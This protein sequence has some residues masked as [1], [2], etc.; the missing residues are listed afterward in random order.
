MDRTRRQ[1]ASTAWGHGTRFIAVGVLVAMVGALLSALSGAPEA[2]ARPA[3]DVHADLVALRAEL[4]KVADEQRSGPASISAADLAVLDQDLRHTED[5]VRA[6]TRD[7]DVSLQG[8][9]ERVG[10]LV[11]RTQQQTRELAAQP[12]R[13]AELARWRQA[14][15]GVE[16]LERQGAA[17]RGK[18]LA[19]DPAHE[20]SEGPITVVI[21][22]DKAKPRIKN[23]PGFDGRTPRPLA[24]L[25]DTEGTQVDF[26]A[27]ELILAT[28]DQAVLRAFVDRWRGTVVRRLHS[29]VRGSTPQY[30]VRIDTDRADPSKLSGDL[31]KLNEGKKKAE[32]LSVSSRVA[33]NLLAAA[34]AEANNKLSIGV[35]WVGEPQTIPA[36]STVEAATGPVGFNN[37]PATP[38]SRNAYDWSYLNSGSVQD[39]G[40]T[41]GW[42]LLDSVDRLDNKIRMMIVD[43]GFRPAVNND[44][45]EKTNLISTVP[46]VDPASPNFESD[47]PW[48]GT[49]VASAAAG[50]PDN[51]RGAAGP[52]GPVAKLDLWYALPD[53]FT[54]TDTIDTATIPVQ[55]ATKILNMSFGL[56]VHWSLS[57]SVLPFEVYTALLR[58]VAGVLLFAAAGND[59][60]NVDRETCFI[61]CWEKYWHTPCENN[62]VLCVGGLERNTLSRAPKSNYGPEHVDIFAPYTVLVGPDPSR[63]ADAAYPVNGTSFSSP[64]AAGVAALIWTANPGLDADDVQSILLRNMR[65]SPDQDVKRR[66]IHAYGAIRDALPA[67]IAIKTPSNDATLAAG[68]PTEFRAAVYKDGHGTPTITWR[69]GNGAVLGTGNPISAALPPGGHDVTVTAAFPDGTTATD[70]IHVTVVNHAPTVEITSPSNAG[71]STPTFARSEPI[72]FHGTSLDPDTGQLPDSRVSWHLD[73]ATASFA[74]GHNPVTTTGAAPGTHTVTFRGCDDFGAC[75]TATVKIAIREDEPNQPPKVRITNPPNGVDLPVNGRDE[76]GVFHELTLQSNV[77][78]PEGDP[79]TLVWT[80]SVDGQPA[81]QI[82][83]GP[84]P[85]VRLYGKCESREHRLTLTATDSAGN[86]RQDTVKVVVTTI[87]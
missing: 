26:V 71:G 34:A 32:L 65:T 37:N 73:G 82:G 75:G 27:N 4:H 57:W 56:A 45:P 16:R 22:P 72:V 81:V 62:G 49:Q 20:G 55:F 42:T 66:V 23:L 68:R 3:P 36:G 87:C 61:G 47:K 70:K 24:A 69:R 78:D 29:H 80:D 52:A 44:L 19:S 1:R 2:S 83:T 28:A 84:S 64:Y 18:L 7:V 5:Q 38:Y 8:F 21:N 60:R 54:V 40:V 11:A 43:Q 25:V 74:T 86:S 35:N 53:I 17:L 77:S 31:A 41:E 79:V 48:H 67:A 33:L 39:I 59:G 76:K 13:E 10:T 14:S 9:T 46:F 63:P 58:H 12:G 85:T 6:G 50:V 15:A 30:L 51:G